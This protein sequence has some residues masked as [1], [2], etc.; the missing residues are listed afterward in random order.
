MTADLAKAIAQTLA[1]LGNADGVY[2]P[3]IPALT[4]MRSGHAVL[5][6]HILYRPSL[7]VV[8]Q[9]AKQVSLDEQTLTYGEGQALVVSVELPALGR[10][11]RASQSE[12]YLGLTLE[13]DP[14]ILRS[15]LESM[16]QP[17]RPVLDKGSPLFVADLDTPVLDC[18]T[19][20]VRLCHSPQAVGVLYPTIMRELC[21][22]LLSGP[23]AAQIV[24]LALPFSPIRR[25]TTAIHLMRESFKTTLRVN[26]LAAAAGMSPSSF[27]Q[28]FKALTAMSPLQYQ[29]Q[30]RLLE[31]RRLMVADD[32]NVTN[33]AFEVGYESP[34]QFSREYARMFGR[35]PKQDAQ[36]A[37]LA[38]IPL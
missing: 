3:P 31:A 28:H 17:P 32:V 23:Y 4:V 21:F 19:R 22:W 10:I 7:C 34:S 33:A 14:D 1:P 29:K 5:P 38:G 30:L 2:R 27:H 20:L 13:F 26:D 18:I 8:A 24:R 35:P 9:G 16:D 6:H 25:I 36:A 15:V 11:S 12:P 37:K